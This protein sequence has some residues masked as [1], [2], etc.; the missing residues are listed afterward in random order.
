MLCTVPRILNTDLASIPK[1]LPLEHVDRVL[2]SCDVETKNGKRD[3][4]ILILLARLGLSV[5]SLCLEDIQWE[6]GTITVRGK[7][8]P[9][10]MPLPADVG[11]ALAQYI[12]D[13]RPKVKTRAIFILLRAP[14][15]AMKSQES[16]CGV[17]RRATE[18]AQIRSPKKG[19][20]QFRHGLATELL[21]APYMMASLR[22]M[23]S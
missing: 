23:S 7:S 11:E 14:I 3:F 21:R 1:A 8:G 18:R 6:S 17:V 4:A 20:H 13:V 2:E 19:A 16:F 15:S 10:V 5:A 12:R 22:A 9:R